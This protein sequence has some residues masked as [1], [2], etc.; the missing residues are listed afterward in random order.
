M[1]QGISAVLTFAVGVAISP[2]P[3]IA[4]I[5]MLFSQRA[6][7]NGPVFLAGWVLALA[8]RRRSGLRRRR[9]QQRRDEQRAPRTRSRGGRSSSAW[10][11]CSSRA[12]SGRA[13]RRP[14]TSRTCR[15]GWRAST[16]SRRPRLSGSPCCSQ[17]VNPKNLL[18]TAGAAAGV[19]QLGISNGDAIVA[20]AVF[21]ILASLTI[22]GPSSTTSSGARRRRPSSTS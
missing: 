5:L 11:S 7:V 6:R 4:V 2:V 13:G 18:L 21:V 15:S 14:V 22:A 20:L 9:R 1:G 10:F 12:S 16:R 8:S 19:A 3:I 17:R